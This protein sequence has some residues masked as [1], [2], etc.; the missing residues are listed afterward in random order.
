[1]IITP[2]NRGLVNISWYL[3]KEVDEPLIHKGLTLTMMF[4]YHGNDHGM[5]V[6]VLP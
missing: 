5:M 2:Q 6:K 1:M 3:G 4:K